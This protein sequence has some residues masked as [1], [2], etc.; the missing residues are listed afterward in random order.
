M[1]RN[2][3]TLVLMLG[4]M[5]MCTNGFADDLRKKVVGKWYNPYTYESTGEMKGFEFKKNGKC[6]A[7]GIPNMNLSGWE[8]KEGRLI[9]KGE[10][11]NP[12][13]GKWENYHTSE[14]ID[15]VNADSLYVLSMEKPMKLGF[16]YM[17][18]KAL[19]KKVVPASK[20][21]DSQT[22]IKKK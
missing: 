21:I 10:Y 4:L 22:V 20:E 16:L 5:C 13:S 6:K 9:I 18:P 12:K 14:K 19:K 1:K 3:F 11:L 2:V 15:R 7:L 8:V 17:S